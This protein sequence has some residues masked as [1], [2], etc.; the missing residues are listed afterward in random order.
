MSR[1]I[2]VELTSIR[3]DQ[4]WT[5]RAAGARQPKGELDAELL[6][7]GAK[8]GDVVRADVETTLDG[9][10]VLSITAPKGARREPERIE[11][12]GRTEPEELVTTTLAPRRGRRDDHDR[13]EGGERRAGRPPRPKGDRPGGERPRGD[14]PRDDRARGERT[15][16]APERSGACPDD[17]T[18]RPRPESGQRPPRPPAPVDARPRAKR[19]R[20]GRAHRK[21]VLEGLPAEHRPVAEQVLRGGIP[22]VRQAVEKQN[23]GARAEGR[24]EVKAD[25][26][27]DLAEKLLPALRSAEW[28]DRAEAALAD[29][30]ELDLRDLRSV[31]VAADHA[32]RDDRTRSLATALREGLTRRVEHEQSSW[33]AE[34]A[35][36]LSDGRAVRALRLSSRPPKAGAPLPPDITTRLIE[37]AESALTADTA[38]DRCATVLDALS[39]SPVHARVTPPSVP[40]EPGAEL[41]TVVR[42]AA[43]QLPQVAALF[44]IEPKAEPPRRRSGS[45]SGG[46]PAG[47][48]VPPRPGPPPPRRAAAPPPPAA[49]AVVEAR[50]D[51]A[52]APPAEPPPGVPS[53]PPLADP[54][55]PEAQAAP[56]SPPT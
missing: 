18:R 41:L 39:F 29:L 40:P 6:P 32:G 50:P 8:V 16:R 52:P 36:A 23:E 5:W 31:I 25:Q 3:G 9:T 47:P 13:T 33:L 11:L 27:V 37:A 1:R 20:P 53:T 35:T 10:V 45:R 24:P 28:L 15:S 43:T 38:P 30:D 56:V 4:S 22:S 46:S 2:D 42:K 12:L 49:P 14:G 17:R 21:E 26:L 51:P 48:P 7:A 54:D 44:G 34:I 55:A 19:L